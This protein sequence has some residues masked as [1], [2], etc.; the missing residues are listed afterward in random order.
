LSLYT[1]QN[2]FD[3]AFLFL[4]MKLFDTG[5]AAWMLIF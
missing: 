1:K 3:S 2:S 5:M 4:S